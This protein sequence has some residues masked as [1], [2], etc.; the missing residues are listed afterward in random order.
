MQAFKHLIAQILSFLAL[1]LVVIVLTGWLLLDTQPLV[2]RSSALSATSVQNGRQLMSSINASM[3]NEAATQLVIQTNADELNAAFAIAARTLP[4]FQGETKLQ[5]DGLSVLMTMPWQFI[6]RTYYVNATIHIEAVQGPLQLKQVQVGKVT[7]PGR[8][9][10]NLLSWVADE[11]WGQG[12]GAQL[13]AKV[14]SVSVHDQE[15]TVELEKPQGFGVSSLKQ[16]GVALYRK[17]T[18]ADSLKQDIE[19]YY[20]LAEQFSRQQQESSLV[21]YLQLVFREAQRRTKASD[22][23]ERAVVENTAAIY[24][25]AQLL[26]GKNL[27]LMVNEV[28]HDDEQAALKVTLARRRDLQQHFIYSATLHLLTSQNMSATVGETKE[29]LDSLQ[30]GSGFSFVDLLADKA[31]ARFARLA[32]LSPQHAQAV[33][34]FF[35]S[36]DRQESDVFP[37]KARLPEGMPKELFEQKYQSI[38]S[39]LY[40]QIVEEIERR[41]DALPLYQLEHQISS[42]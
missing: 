22:D 19:I 14:R 7:L 36:T 26:G 5:S 40:Q 17:F 42:N 23:P 8:F 3:E 13:L 29:L 9:A 18:G 33:Q 34:A 25:L 6:G 37:S 1:L 28:K 2:E 35:S 24:G 27:Q 30:G 12:S 39:T 15:L 38:D 10:L 32:T 41:L 21:P 31:G 20:Q 4:G 11:A 16:Q